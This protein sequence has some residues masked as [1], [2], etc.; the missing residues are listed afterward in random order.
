MRSIARQTPAP[1]SRRFLVL[2]LETCGASYTVRAPN[3]LFDPAAVACESL[4][5]AVMTK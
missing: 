2:V 1:A 3:L 5:W 4:R